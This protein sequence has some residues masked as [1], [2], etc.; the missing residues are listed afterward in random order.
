MDRIS[1]NGDLLYTGYGIYYNNIPGLISSIISCVKKSNNQYN[2][3]HIINHYQI[4][5]PVIT[6][7]I[8]GLIKHKIFYTEKSEFISDKNKLKYVSNL[9]LYKNIEKITI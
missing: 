8:K 5:I 4:S 9:G 7:C 6:L 2:I 3:V 1:R